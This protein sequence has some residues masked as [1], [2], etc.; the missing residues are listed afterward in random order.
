MI[1]DPDADITETRKR[2]RKKTLFEKNEALLKIRTFSLTLDESDHF[3]NDTNGQ[4]RG[5]GTSLRADSPVKLLLH[6]MLALQTFSL[7]AKL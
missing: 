4:W 7:N 2:C 3:F 1:N 6:S 5:H